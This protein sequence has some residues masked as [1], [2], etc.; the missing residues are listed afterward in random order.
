MGHQTPRESTCRLCLVDRRP[1]LVHL[2]HRIRPTTVDQGASPLGWTWHSADSQPRRLIDLFRRTRPSTGLVPNNSRQAWISE[3]LGRGLRH[4]NSRT[5]RSGKW[6]CLRISLV[7]STSN[8]LASRA[9]LAYHVE[10]DLEQA[11]RGTAPRGAME[12]VLA[13]APHHPC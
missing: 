8:R 2:D 13:L 12:V 4:L 1:Q 10:L 9:A 11:M 3:C 6:E 5:I 7:S